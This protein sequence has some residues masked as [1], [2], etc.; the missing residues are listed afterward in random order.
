MKIK[1][2]LV[3]DVCKKKNCMRDHT[4]DGRHKI[5]IEIEVR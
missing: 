5:P 1:E 3:T 4:E 2:I